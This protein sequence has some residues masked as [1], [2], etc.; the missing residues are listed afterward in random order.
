[1]LGVG[2]LWCYFRFSYLSLSGFVLLRWNG[3]GCDVRI[4]LWMMEGVANICVF[5]AIHDFSLS[6]LLPVVILSLTVAARVLFP[7]GKSVLPNCS[8][9]LLIIPIYQK[10]CPTI[11]PSPPL[12]C[13]MM[14]R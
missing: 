8:A 5:T 14:L 9:L 12:Y 7:V 1:M 6:L 13:S 2:G 3:M 10:V 11:Q 4:V